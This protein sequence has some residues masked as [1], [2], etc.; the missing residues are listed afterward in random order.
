VSAL[1]VT[2]APLVEVHDF[3]TGLS[4]QVTHSGNQFSWPLH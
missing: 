4:R 1:K 3:F 2:A